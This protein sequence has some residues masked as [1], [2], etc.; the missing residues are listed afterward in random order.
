MEEGLTLYLA[1]QV[2]I[3]ANG[4][5]ISEYSDIRG[6]QGREEEPSELLKLYNFEAG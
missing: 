6:G 5:R 3:E 2:K 4:L 1:P